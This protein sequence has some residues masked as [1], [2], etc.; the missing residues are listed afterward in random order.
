MDISGVEVPDTSN[1]GNNPTLFEGL[2]VVPTGPVN[3][4]P[5]K[6]YYPGTVVL[7]DTATGMNVEE[8]AQQAAQGVADAMKKAK[9]EKTYV[10]YTDPE[11]MSPPEPTSPPPPEPVPTSVP[12]PVS[13]MK[14]GQ[15]S[16]NPEFA[17]MNEVVALMDNEGESMSGGA[18]SKRRRPKKRRSKRRRSEKRRSK[19]RRSE[20]RR[21]EKRRSKKRRSNKHRSKRR[22]SKKPIRKHRTQRKKNNV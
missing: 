21:S 16:D 22:R 17:S 9:K 2:G 13:G 15:L 12:V 7:K 6:I 4:E 20:R 18:G 5:H 14:L 1:V 11:A 19:K 3:L 8:G 10:K